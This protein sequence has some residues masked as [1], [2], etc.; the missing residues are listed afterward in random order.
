ML[1]LVGFIEDELNEKN[2]LGYNFEHLEGNINIYGQHHVMCIED[3]NKSEVNI[4]HF[5]G[6]VIYLVGQIF[7][8]K[9]KTICLDEFF[10]LVRQSV[11]SDINS[12]LKSIDGYYSLVIFDTTNEECYF[13]TDRLGISPLY[14]SEINGGLSAWATSIKS[15]D[16]IV[17]ESNVVDI[18][19]LRSFVDI[20][21]YLSDKTIY[22]NIKR[23]D[24]ATILHIDKSGKVLSRLRYWTWADIQ[25]IKFTFEQA[26]DR[27]YILFLQA[28]ESRLDSTKKYC[29]TL[30]GGLDSRALLGAISHLKKY[31]ITCLTFGI[32]NSP[33]VKI[34]EQASQIVGVKHK[35]INID[36]S[37]W[38][39][40]R[41]K[42]VIST[43]GMKSLFHMH[44]LNSLAEI[45]SISKY[46]ING[47]LGDLVLGGGYLKKGF[48]GFRSSETIAYD[49][50]S[51][52]AD[53]IDFDED[54]F[55]HPSSDPI[56]IYNRGVRF[57]SMGSDLVNDR[58][59][60]IKPFVDN[61][62]LE[63]VYGLDDSY[64]VNGKLYHSM[65]VKYFPELFLTLPWQA[66]GKCIVYKD[67][68]SVINEFYTII[69]PKLVK[70]ISES[71]LNEI[72]RNVHSI[73]KNNKT[74]VDYGSWIS[75]PDFKQNIDLLLSDDSCTVN[76]LGSKV[77]K[78]YVREAFE[79]QKI[80][81]LGCLL[82][83]ESYLKAVNKSV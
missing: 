65:L 53:Q 77:V 50:F 37:N 40:G 74:F 59:V 16:D 44:V 11:N 63:F 45:E 20:S 83:V 72:V 51:H 76:L 12:L 3:V 36:K 26:V 18:E 56:F 69:R 58:L 1:A 67:K 60:N 25:P 41:Q 66:T 52:Y 17:V 14:L 81:A 48:H 29:L 10:E 73:I 62:L 42:G 27:L 68:D 33:D 4:R 61:E 64:R 49:K 39:N 55:K 70:L 23:L 35:V 54:Y 6:L 32:P 43:G 38:I 2:K 28:V 24:P 19:A 9:N 15:L 31:D 8:H 78:K 7:K 34:A 57:T 46:V 47:Y 5:D 30:S 75:E 82:S 22:K 13:I 21:H 80:E 79:E 71:S